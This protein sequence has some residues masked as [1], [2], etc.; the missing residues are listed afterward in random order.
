MPE[1]AGGG[2]V[3]IA[4]DDGTGQV[5]GEI[6]GSSSVD[7]ANG[8]VVAVGVAVVVRSGISGRPFAVAAASVPVPEPGDRGVVSI[9]EADGAGGV[10]RRVVGPFSVDRAKGDVVAAGAAAVVRSGL[11]GRPVAVAVAA[12]FVPV[13]EPGDGGI[14]GV[15]EGDGAREVHGG[16]EG[17]SPVY[18]P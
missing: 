16:V 7:R 13:A 15:A 1:S 4:K 12:A 17:T 14:V 9:T 8:A 18:R 2:L 10:P 6:V 11:A 3:G 5:P